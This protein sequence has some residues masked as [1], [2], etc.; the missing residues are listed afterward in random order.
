MKDQLQSHLFI[1]YFKNRKQNKQ[2]AALFLWN[3]GNTT[4]TIW[5]YANKLLFGSS[6]AR[7]VTTLDDV[8]AD[9]VHILSNT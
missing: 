5:L 4:Y 9:N 1:K 8:G 7:G 2:T 3:A 6:L